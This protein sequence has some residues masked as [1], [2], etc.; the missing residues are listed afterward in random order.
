LLQVTAESIRT[1]E[2][3]P[4]RMDCIPTPYNIS[5]TW[6]FN[7]IRILD[8]SGVTFS[9]AHLN[10]TLIISNVDVR[11]SGAYSCQVVATSVEPVSRTIILNV[12]ESM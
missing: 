9:P 12:L 6:G 11:D 8:Q 5:I 7:G 4:I 2:S 1:L 3:Q 10:H